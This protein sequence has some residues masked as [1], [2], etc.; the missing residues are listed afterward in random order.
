M[1]IGVPREVKSGERRVG[2]DAH[3]VRALAGEGFAVRVERGAGAGIG[4]SDDD[5]AR[6]GGAIVAREEAWGSDLV[7]KVKEV[8]DGEW[9]WLRTGSTLFSFQHLVGAPAQTRRLASAGVNVIAFEMVRDAQG[10]F[11]ILAPMSVLAGRLAIEA[12]AAH[13]SGLAR[14]LVLGAGHAGREAVRCALERGSQVTVLCRR[15]ASRD[16][17]LAQFGAR[18]EAGLAT[19]ENIEQAALMADA[20]VGAV[21]VAGSATPKLLPRA[22]VAR[23]KRGAVIVDVCIEEGGIAETSRPTSH[24]QPTFVEE[25]VVHYAVGNMP[26]SVPDVATQALAKAALPYARS[27][28][29]K[30]ALRALR[31]DAGLRAGMLLW[32]GQVTH[33]GIAKEAGLAC[34]ALP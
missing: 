6:A 18:I 2:L 24:A 21:F 34:A 33:A 27:L 11:P 22:L 32:N 25:G 23:M 12:A 16:A 1:N 29:A 9:D 26:A 4:T 8:Q 10:G 20:V 28:A 17:L 15:K 13:G 7:V 14:V 5:Y 31:D 3:A 19:L 30:G